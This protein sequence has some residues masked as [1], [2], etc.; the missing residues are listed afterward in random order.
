MVRLSRSTLLPVIVFAIGSIMLAG[1]AVWQS[2]PQAHAEQTASGPYGNRPDTVDLSN[3]YNPPAVYV[4]GQVTVQR[5][6]RM[7]TGTFPVL[8]ND[9]DILGDL[10]YR[11]E[12]YGDMK[13]QEGS[14]DPQ[15]LLARSQA[16]DLPSLL[17]QESKQISYSYDMPDLPNGA[18]VVQVQILH[19]RGRELGWGR[20]TFEV[21]D[22]TDSFAHFYSSNIILPEFQNQ[23]VE[24]ISGPNVNGGSTFSIEAN[25][26][27]V[28][29]HAVTG[30]PVLDIYS[31]DE[32][33]Q[34]I[35]QLVFDPITLQ[36]GEEKKVIFPVTAQNAAGIYVGDLTLQK[37][38]KT[39][40]SI[41]QYRWVVRGM[42]ADVLSARI[43]ALTTTKGSSTLARVEYVGPAD[44][45]TSGVGQMTIELNDEKGLLASITEPNVKLTDG[46]GVGMAKLTLTRD[47]VG[48]PSL[49]V[50]ID[51]TD[52]KTLTDYTA[53]TTLNAA[54]IKS[55]SQSNHWQLWLRWYTNY[56]YL[57]LALLLITLAASIF[58]IARRAILHTLKLD[59]AFKAV[60]SGL[61]VVS[62]F[63]MSSPLAAANGIDVFTAIT[64]HQNAIYNG[65]PNKEYQ[66]WGAIWESPIVAL[67]VNQPI[68]DAP[69]G[70]YQ[71]NGSI[72]LEYRVDYAACKNATTATRVIGRFDANGG[73]QTSLLGSNANWVKVYDNQFTDPPHCN[74]AGCIFSKTFNATV[75]LSGLSP[76]ATA[77]TLQVVV[78]HN[79]YEDGTH[80]V[81][82]DVVSLNDEYFQRKFAAAVNLFIN[83][84]SPLA[85]VTIQKSGPATIQQGNTISYSLIAKNNGPATAQNVNVTDAIPAGLSYLPGQSDGRCSQQGNN[86]V[87]SLGSMTSGQ[88]TS[89]NLTFQ[90][91]QQTTCGPLTNVANISTT[92]Q[93]SNANNN[94]SQ[95]TTQVQCQPQV[96]CINV[97]KI[98][99][100]A[101]GNVMSPVPQF[102]FQ[103][104]NGASAF[105]DQS[106]HTSFQNVPVGQHNVTEVQQSGWTMQSGNGSVNVV[107]GNACAQVT[108]I[109]RQN[110]ASSSSSA[111]PYT[112]VTVQK[113]GDS[114]VQQGNVI[115]YTLTAG[116]IGQNPAQNVVVTDQIPNGLTYIQTDGR[117]N[118][119]GS[120][121]RCNLGTLNVGQQT[122][123]NLQF[124]TSQQTSCGPVTNVATI[125]T[126][127]PETNTGNNSSSYQTQVQCQASSSSQPPQPGC[128]NIT[129]V[130]LNPV[131]SSLS[132]VPQFQFFL[133]G[134]QQTFN[135]ASG[136]ASFQS[137]TAGTHTVTEMIPTGWSQLS[138]VP[139]NGVVTVQ[140]GS[141]C[142][143]VTFTN[144]QNPLSSSSSSSSVTPYTDV[145]I[146]K[147]GDA[148]VSPG[149]II[150][151]ALTASNIGQNAAQ[152]VTVNDQIPS[153]L[154]YL[155]NQSDNRCSQQGN[156]IV[157]NLG[158]LNV[159]QQTTINLQFQTS[160]QM[161]C[162][163]ITNVATISTSTPETNT[164]NNS[165]QYTT[166]VQCQASSSS[167]PTQ[168]GC[169]DVLKEAFDP[170]GNEL[171]TVPQFQ[172]FL[173]GTNPMYN[174]ST[175]HL[176]FSNVTP[177]THTV[178]ELVPNGWSQYL[179]TPVNGV[180]Y[181]Q[182]GG[183]CV[184]V[185]F[186][187]RQN[188]LS[189]S[190]SSANGCIDIYKTAVD[191]NNNQIYYVPSFT[192]TLDNNQNATNDS[193]G[194]AHFDNVTAGQHTISENVQNGW[195]MVS[196]SPQNGYVNVTPGGACAA[197][198][199]RNQQY[200]GG[201]NLTITKDDG[202][203]QVQPGDHLTYTIRVT[204]N[205]SND[206]NNVTVTDSL[207]N[208]L[209]ARNASNG[210]YVNNQYVTWNNLYIPAFSSRTL[211]LNADV[212]NDASGN[213][214]NRAQINN[215]PTAF[216]TDYVEQNIS[217]SLSL[218][219]TASTQE[220]FP[221]G[222][223]EYTVQLR[224]TGNGT[225]QNLRVTDNLPQDVNVVDDGGADQH[226]GNQLEWNIGSLSQN[227]IRTITYRIILGGSWQ[228]GSNVVNS[229]E[230]RADNGIDEH[231][232]TTVQ[233]IGMLPQTGFPGMQ[234][235]PT[236]HLHPITTGTQGSNGMPFSPLFV[237]LAFAGLAAGIGG[238]FMRRYLV[239]F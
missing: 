152:N 206:A 92:T 157:C 117:C 211:T 101:N 41:G 216:D 167:I 18:Y 9:S 191:Q 17:P 39:V 195:S 97:T 162:G 133:D 130:A 148:S 45:E 116:N 155:S 103:L 80:G 11:I 153:G 59:R 14:G 219:K 85:D 65:D 110:P 6:G 105:N 131:G 169:I 60:T 113:T 58:Y 20:A 223:I 212:D 231:A 233:V 61:L 19:A 25:A 32:S 128:I 184:G 163:P 170:N 114:F 194:H 54:Q 147:T 82:N 215:G 171:N 129:K 230:A 98:A 183:S 146:Q 136:H 197:V 141:N 89:I 55:A 52:G 63:L 144:R 188:A 67:F 1:F 149:G 109:N 154:S 203:S 40:S 29:D 51:T 90:S 196:M 102:Q 23:E 226:N 134:S 123:I 120:S 94:S 228:P 238:G 62:T 235:P 127:T 35:G 124:Q 68:H 145:T 74:A 50:T 33:R 205:G 185:T 22:G 53:G 213:L 180:V 236:V 151:Y 139:A 48:S 166:Q 76:S 187:N 72:P 218:T 121:V 106:G 10:Q 156:T 142:A 126:T 208:G 8:N 158:A 93:E 47:L 221:G 138:V 83:C 31:F 143:Q 125:S 222:T 174:D 100:D 69:A 34:K 73:K 99:Y 179:V 207:P 135:D 64:L 181:V 119:Q 71:C 234:N 111:T 16:F 189:S 220:V 78:K 132:P 175:G 88:Q 173:D 77:T 209:T 5:D 193:S 210:G 4:D 214:T 198:Y 164:G 95:F 96:G 56:R 172:F 140:P 160:Q 227:A 199:I 49:H 159:G 176:R 217:T 66:Y 84:A 24:G 38:D 2:S 177:G 30:R 46:V 26:V 192:F 168:T 190:S 81:P 15:V 28:T 232:S 122:T 57:I 87:C 43:A 86:V 42:S 202:R 112:D 7:L 182:P 115:H 21:Q 79:P 75:N 200:G 36:P 37:N 118:L 224:N 13:G 201:T 204:N 165:S 186:K 225:I 108:F 150:H 161:A 229:V 91:S 237:W 27:N 70:T 137:V 12:V 239:G 107:A 104:D 44:A 178:S 3:A